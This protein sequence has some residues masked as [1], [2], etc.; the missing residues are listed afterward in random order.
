MGKNKTIK[1]IS[2]VAMAFVS[3]L[4]SCVLTGCSKSETEQ[5][6]QTEGNTKILTDKRDRRKNELTEQEIAY[7]TKKLNGKYDIIAQTGLTGQASSAYLMEDANGEKYVLRIPV[8]EEKAKDWIKQQK[9]TIQL[10]QEIFKD[11]NYNGADIPQYFE[12][13]DDYIVEKYLGEDLTEELYNQLSDEEK[14]NIAKDIANFLVYLHSQHPKNVKTE[15]WGLIDEKDLK[16]ESLK[17]LFSVCKLTEDEQKILNSKIN[18][19]QHRNTDDEVT[20]LTHRD[21]R[22]QNILYNKAT[23][24]V[25]IV[26]FEIMAYD[27]VYM[28]F[29]KYAASLYELPY[30]LLF[31]MIDFYNAASDIKIDKDKVKFLHEFYLLS[32]YQVAEEDDKEYIQEI[33]DKAKKL[34]QKLEEAYNKN[35]KLKT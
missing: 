5:K 17:K 31:N 10:V 28:D 34:I 14:T 4:T 11:Y 33:V 15:I 24:K 12:I 7:F 21:I 19:F 18:N 9:E 3:S 23:K 30:E 32:E 8:S 2:A 25:G 35:T 27:N 26:D 16:E 29:F 6:I 1:C 20:V 13:G 22:A